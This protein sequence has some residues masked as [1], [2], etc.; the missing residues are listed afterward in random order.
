LVDL[1]NIDAASGLTNI[2]LDGDNLTNTDT[3]SDTV[4]VQSTNGQVTTVSLLAGQGND[5]FEVR[6]TTAPATIDGIAGQVFV[7]PTAGSFIDDPAAADGDTLF[8][9]DTGDLTGDNVSIR[10]LTIEGIT[11]F[12]GSPDISYFNIDTLDVTGTAGND[13]FDTVLNSGTDLDVVSV[14][15][16]DGNEQFYLDL[17]TADDTTN[18]V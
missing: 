15:G 18:I 4:R 10:E 7:S 11:G 3:A 5:I 1:A 8:V 14:N 16:F 6:K 13:V 2:V 12:A 17:N 9:S